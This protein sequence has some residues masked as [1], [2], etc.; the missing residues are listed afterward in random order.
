MAKWLDVDGTQG[1]GGGQI[2]R[3]SLALSLVTGTPFRLHGVR[4]GRAKPGLLRQHL[5][6]IRAA[7][8]VGDA[9]VEGDAIGSKEVSFRPRGLRGGDHRFAVGTAGSATLVFQTVLP[10]LLAAPEPS[11]LVLEGGTHNSAAPPYDFLEK[12]HLPLLRRMGARVGTHLERRGYYPAGGGRFTA[13]V[14]PAGPLRPLD[15]PARGEIARRTA[16]VCLANLDGAIGSRETG[17]LRKLLPADLWTF[18]AEV[19]TDGRGPGNVVLLE[20]EAEHVTEVF[21]AFGS[22]GVRAEQVA[23]SAV[24]EYRAWLAADVP[25]G[26]HLAD[27]LLI[28]LAMAG[29]GSF[30]T[31]PP[32]RHTLTN[33]DVVG[34]FLPDRPI[35][36]E[37]AGS[38]ATISVRA[39]AAA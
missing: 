22:L 25:V 34:L 21:A 31:L 12:V 30:R 26:A 27:Q 5:T 35:E 19:E 3:T 38:A 4:A 29:G 8:A 37:V 20:V 33:R 16:R 11:S 23:Q 2:L 15:L 1:E 10:A 14:E 36:I 24:E 7:A 17:M 13:R 32:T 9:E 28:P 39:R 6:A 18:H